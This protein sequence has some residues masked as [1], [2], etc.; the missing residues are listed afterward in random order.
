MG[1]GACYARADAS[2]QAEDSTDWSTSWKKRKFELIA[3]PVAQAVEEPEPEEP[4]RGAGAAAAAPSPGRGRP[5]RKAAK[6][7]IQEELDEE[8]RVVAVTCFHWESGL[9]MLAHCVR[10][11]CMRLCGLGAHAPQA[12]APLACGMAHIASSPVAYVG[13]H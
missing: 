6:Q 2:A 7:E 13:G 4:G 11:H 9:C 3:T 1:L 12:A 10:A 5:S 8:V